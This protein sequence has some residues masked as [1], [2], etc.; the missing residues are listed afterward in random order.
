[1]YFTEN[2]LF[3]FVAFINNAAYGFDAFWSEA[4]PGIRKT[5]RKVLRAQLVVDARGRIDVN[6]VDEVEGM[7]SW[8]L[9]AA[10]RRDGRAAFDPALVGNSPAGLAA[11]LDRVVSNCVIDYCRMFHGARSDVKDVSLSDLELNAAAVPATNDHD[12]IDSVCRLEDIE[13]VRSCL[14]RLDAIDRLVLERTVCDG[15]SQREL[16]GELRVS[17]TTAFRMI[18]RAKEN[19]QRL[20]AA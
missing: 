11:W 20:L 12:V 18:S 9:S 5:A 4:K 6:A 7:V 10:A 16:A 1:M 3:H 17:A 14:N 15:L 2:G 8:K 19:L 13:L